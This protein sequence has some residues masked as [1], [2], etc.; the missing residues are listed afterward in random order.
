MLRTPRRS[1]ATGIVSLSRRTE[2]LPVGVVM[3]DLAHTR[4]E[5]LDPL[6]ERDHRVPVRIRQVLQ[7]PRLARRRIAPG[8][9]SRRRPDRSGVRR[10][11]FEHDR[12]RA[13]SGPCPNCDRAEYRRADADDR[14]I[15]D[16][17]VSLAA[18]L[19]RPAQRHPLVYGDVV[20]DQGGLTND[21]AHTVIDEDTLAEPCS[22]MNLD[23]GDRPTKMCQQTRGEKEARAPQPVRYSV[24]SDGMEPRRRQNRLDCRA[25]GRVTLADGTNFPREEHGG[26][27]SLS[28]DG[29]TWPRGSQCSA[30]A[31]VWGACRAPRDRSSGLRTQ[32]RGARGSN[33]KA[34][35]PRSVS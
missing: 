21:N 31:A 10:H 28:A 27:L 22:R 11:V 16:G 32:S 20:T 15:L 1:D 24:Q 18:L 26:G 19:P 4:L 3:L 14:V 8:D 35:C 9:G 29:S 7:P 6:H 33:G 34:A 2:R 25:R 12:T 13:D 5:F 30:A 23:P 17:G